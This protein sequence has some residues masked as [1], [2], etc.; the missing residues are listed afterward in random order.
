MSQNEIHEAVSYWNN[1]AVQFQHMVSTATDQNSDESI[2]ANSTDTSSDNLINDKL[3]GYSCPLGTLPT[4]VSSA[5]MQYASTEQQDS[6]TLWSDPLT[7]G[8]IIQE[9]DPSTIGTQT[10]P[11]I[12]AL[13]STES[14]TLA[15]NEPM[16]SIPKPAP[17][18]SAQLHQNRVVTQ[19]TLEYDNMVLSETSGT[20]SNIADEIG[21]GQF[22]RGPTAVEAGG[23][24]LETVTASYIAPTGSAS[25]LVATGPL[26]QS[27][28]QLHSITAFPSGD[29]TLLSMGDN[30]PN[31]DVCL[32]SANANLCSS[33]VL[34][35]VFD[36]HHHIDSY[37]HS[38]RPLQQ[39]QPFEPSSVNQTT[40]ITHGSHQ[41]GFYP[42]HNNHLNRM[43]APCHV[44][45]RYVTNTLE[46]ST[47]QYSSTLAENNSLYDIIPNSQTSSPAEDCSSLDM[48]QIVDIKREL[49]VDSERDDSTNSAVSV[50]CN[51][52]E[53]Q[54][55]NTLVSE[56]VPAIL[57]SVM[58]DTGQHRHHLYQQEEQQHRCEVCGKSGFSTKG[59]LK[60]H[61]RAHSGEKPFKCDY[62][63]SCFT[64]KKSLKIHLRRHTG[65]K[66]YKCHVCEKYFSQTGVLQSHMALHLNERKFECQKCGKAFRQRSQLK[67]HLM[68]HDG[69][70][71]LE[72]QTCKAK[73]L[74]KGDLERHC[75]IHTGERPYRCDLCGKTFTRQQSLNEHMNRHTGKKP[76]YCKFCDKKF[77]E[78]SACYKVSSLIEL[79]SMVQ[80]QLNLVNSY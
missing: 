33:A 11:A 3:S 56:A 31:E 14:T 76:Y 7:N 51:S 48:E 21:N 70:K 59:N 27:N 71:R 58:H 64:E 69:V 63:D 53:L 65:E 13:T 20:T 1:V 8:A 55:A 66:P 32:N 73:F 49:I 50:M 61:L 5:L 2:V 41:D 75:R 23:A 54:S 43:R 46:Q 38:N 12:Q 10:Q 60:R 15:T 9:S 45:N 34:V 80:R 37:T 25:R 47:V 17:P 4:P 67:L 44:N 19:P 6:A 16:V 30:L 40:N 62:C 26:L 42:D 72:C 68:R 24:V 52:S 39:I 74:T 57:E 18:V 78:M 79:R 28:T 22:D 36:R 35:P 77:S 29:P